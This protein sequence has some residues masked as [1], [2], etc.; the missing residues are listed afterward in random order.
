MQL[1]AI[2]TL[3]ALAMH[4]KPENDAIRLQSFLPYQITLLADR[5]A[6]Q[7]AAVARRHDGLNLSHWRVLAAVAEK[8]GRT[9]NDVVAVTP[10][11][12]GIVSRAVKS[13]I[14]MN[15][16]SRKSSKDDG[17]IG[18]L[19]LTAKGARRYHSMAD[20]VRKVDETLKTALSEKECDA[21]RNILTRLIVNSA[22]AGKTQPS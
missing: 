12:K 18:H 3:W 19:F 13:L 5:I 9:A 7:T 21:L 6:R 8:P 15:L 10:M 20:E 14:D 2:T 17:R 22:P 11:D 16:I 4:V 1:V